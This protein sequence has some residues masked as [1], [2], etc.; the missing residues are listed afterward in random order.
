MKRK[1]KKINKTKTI[2]RD[3]KFSLP[4]HQTPPSD[5]R[6]TW[7]ASKGTGAD[8][9]GSER[10]ARPQDVLC[11]AFARHRVMQ[12]GRDGC[13]C[14]SLVSNLHFPYSV[15]LAVHTYHQGPTTYLGSVVLLYL[16]LTHIYSYLVP[17]SYPP[18]PEVDR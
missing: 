3:R 9:R 14:L 2:E 7:Q 5:G 6:R 11:S 17:V 15:L 16:I 1:K 8:R 18:V 12:S 13:E 10:K 4:T